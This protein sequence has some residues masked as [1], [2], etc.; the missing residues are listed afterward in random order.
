MI[1]KIIDEPENRYS[2]QK[3]TD[4]SRHKASGE[5][6]DGGQNDSDEPNSPNN[7]HTHSV[8]NAPCREDSPL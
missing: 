3:R 2:G 5:E 4:D 6:A 1:A 7:F 8:A